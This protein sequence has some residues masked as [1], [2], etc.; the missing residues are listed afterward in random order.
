MIKV[1]QSGIQTTI[2]DYGRYGYRSFGI[3]VSG[4]L[5]TYSSRLAN[6]LAGNEM[7]APVLEMVQSPHSF[8]FDED[9]L[10][11][12]CGGGLIPSINGSPLPLFEPLLIEKGAIVDI[13]KPIEG[14][15]LYM[16]V[17][18]GFKASSFL[19]SC[20]THLLSA[21]GG[22]EGRVIKKNDI[23]NMLQ[24]SSVSQHIAGLLKKNLFFNIDQSLSPKIHSKEIRI[25][26]GHEYEL[27]TD[28]SR[29]NLSAHSFHL[30]ND[31]NRMGYRLKS[32]MLQLKE[33]KEMI[34]TAVTKGTIQLL[35]DGQTILLMSDCQTAGGYSRIGQI[36]EADHCRC[37]Q[38]K[39]GDEI[40][41][42]IISLPEAERLYLEQEQRLLELQQKVQ[43]IFA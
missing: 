6:I 15:R 14:F 27:L 29:V 9:C 20:S 26:T 35:P 3:S 24:P 34:S 22:F 39:P 30:T 8:L 11:S 31:Y 1:L 33:K 16:A 19:N 40:S 41:F 32:E 43:Q 2:Q 36:I 4:V 5:S 12:F 23:L 28:E 10:V 13:K 18:G 21:T 17:A 42:Q 7:N 25:I 37:A 38:L